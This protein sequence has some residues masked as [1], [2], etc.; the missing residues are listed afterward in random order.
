[1]SSR[2]QQIVATSENGTRDRFWDDDEESEDEN[3]DQPKNKGHVMVNG[4]PNLATQSSKVSFTPRAGRY[5]LD[6]IYSKRKNGKGDGPTPGTPFRIMMFRE[7]QPKHGIYSWT[8]DAEARAYKMFLSSL[9]IHGP[10]LQAFTKKLLQDYNAKLAWGNITVYRHSLEKGEHRWVRNRK[11][12]IRHRPEKGVCI[13]PKVAESFLGD[14]QRYIM[15]R[16]FLKARGVI[17]RRGYLLHGEPGTGKTSL[18]QVAATVFGLK[19]YIISMSRFWGTAADLTE[20]INAMEKPG[21]LL[22]EDLDTANVK[23]RQIISAATEVASSGTDASPGSGKSKDAALAAL[24]A[25]SKSAGSSGGNGLLETL[26]QALDGV[27]AAQDRIAIIT[28]NRVEALDKALI[29]P[30]RIDVKIECGL[31]TDQMAEQMFLRFFGPLDHSDSD[32]GEKLPSQL[33]P[34]EAERL[35]KL[36]GQRLGGEKLSGADLENYCVTIFGD[37]KKGVDGAVEWKE[38]T[39]AEKKELETKRQAAAVAKAG[40]K[41]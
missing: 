25:E 17:T 11:D 18:V 7:L 35:A 22:L 12:K 16:E 24:L 9:W 26:L 2:Q 15:Q 27:G 31:A 38:K 14:M 36:F 20:L 39:L 29:R 28:T 13:S 34:E 6:G 19:M 23:N 4:R 5:W 3:D 32:E 1:M 33:S 40:R 10:A 41:G 21:I 37:P 8:D 30:G